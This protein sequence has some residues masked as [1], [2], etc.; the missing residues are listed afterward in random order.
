MQFKVLACRNAASLANAAIGRVAC[1]LPTQ[2]RQRM[3][4][5]RSRRVRCAPIC[6]GVPLWS[7]RMLGVTLTLAPVSP[8]ASAQCH[9]TWQQIP[10]PGPGQFCDGTCLNNLGVVAGFI[11]TAGDTETAF[12]WSAA[13]GRV[14]L[15]FPPG[16]ISM[17]A[18]GINDS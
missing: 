5:P 18:T 16:Y 12:V 1:G 10:N 3:M 4:S 13:A 8:R 11:S 9:Y 2:G 17:R 14:H 6:H 15:P 7:V